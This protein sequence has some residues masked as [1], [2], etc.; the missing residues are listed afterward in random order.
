MG[1]NTRTHAQVRVGT[2]SLA[3][4]LNFFGVGKQ[5]N[6]PPKEEISKNWVNIVLLGSKVLFAKVSDLGI[7]LSWS[8]LGTKN[9][10]GREKVSK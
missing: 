10:N 6:F 3:H 5:S 7:S 2:H 8:F 1:I 4:S 9:T